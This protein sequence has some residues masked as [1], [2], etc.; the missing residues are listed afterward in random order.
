MD[1]F[2]KWLLEQK[3][4]QVI[5]SHFSKSDYIPVDLSVNSK[6]FQFQNPKTA[7]EY[8][9]ILKSYIAL[10]N[11]KVGF[12]GYLEKRNL[13]QRS[14][15][16]TKSSSRD[17][18][19]HLGID[20]W[21]DA[22]TKVLAAFDGEIHSFQNNT[23]LGD[24]GPTIILKHT[25]NSFHF[26]TLYGHLSLESIEELKMGQLFKKGETIATL[27]EAKVNGDYA[28]HLH[29]QIIRDIQDFYG[30]YPGVCSEEQLSFYQKNCPNPNLI[31]QLS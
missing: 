15:L 22:G 9:V 28:P 3:D 13:Y 24:Y 6:L 26:Y 23:A 31:L 21:I 25:L 30:D 5:D 18:S 27:G 8:E 11:G 2:E 17:R 20:L 29:F 1:S 14:S 12:G 4:T 19:I 16:F 7:D 10:K